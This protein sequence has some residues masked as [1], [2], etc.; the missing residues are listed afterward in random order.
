MI[1]S[2]PTPVHPLTPVRTPVP[3][4]R[5]RNPLVPIG[6]TGLVMVALGAVASWFTSDAFDR[7]LGRLDEQALRQAGVALDKAV[8][9]QRGQALSQVRLLADDNR[10]RA[11][12][13]TPRFDEA[14]VRDVLDDLRKATGASVMAVLDSAGKVGAVSGLDSL[15]K[16]TLGQ[17]AAVKAAMEKATADV[18]SFPDRV[19]VIGLAPILSGNQVAALMMVGY[20][21][22]AP[23]LAA[24][25]Q[26]S[27]VASALVVADKVV[28]R[29]NADGALA[30]AFEAGKSLADGQSRAVELGRGFLARVTRTS[31]GAA[32]ARA[33]WLVGRHHQAALF[34]PVPQ[35]LWMPAVA[36]MATVL[37]M[38]LL[39]IVWTR[40]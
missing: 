8:E 34:G 3:R 6:I 9:S 37:A 35:V 25:E 14:T 10:V 5:K 40:R 18:W 22:G 15:K 2:V 28:A 11:T 19:L 4:P 29:S 26:S 32:A 27:G 1:R 30:A 39:S 12:V 33:V 31:E 21:L 24:I 17:T 13:I 36:V 23:A 38:L 7:S 20:E 16:E